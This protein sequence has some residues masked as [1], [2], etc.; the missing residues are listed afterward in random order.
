MARTRFKAKIKMESPVQA[1][2]SKAWILSL[3]T[4]TKLL[5]VYFMPLLKFLSWSRGKKTLN[6]FLMVH[7]H[8]AMKT[9]QDPHAAYFIGC[10]WLWLHAVLCFIMMLLLSALTLVTFCLHHWLSLSPFSFFSVHFL[11]PLLW[12]RLLLVLHR[13][14]NHSRS[15]CSV[16]LLVPLQGWKHRDKS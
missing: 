15:D 4:R 14:D 3:L 13:H 12:T 8:G 6:I 16:D 9:K 2:E 1:Q 5:P 7:T 11:F 10:F